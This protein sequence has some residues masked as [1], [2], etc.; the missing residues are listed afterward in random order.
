MRRTGQILA[1]VALALSSASAYAA[2]CAPQRLATLDIATLPAGRI[3]VPVTVEGHPLSFLLDTGGV[4]TTIKWDLAK[5]MGLAVKQADRRLHGMGDSTLNFVLASDK[6]SVG[7]LNLTD[8]PIYVE[9]RPL[10]DV[11]GTLSPDILRDYDVEIDLGAGHMNLFASGYCAMPQWLGGAVL[12]IDVVA[13][14]H[15][16][17]PVKIDGIRFV[18]VLDTGSANSLISMRAAALLS[19]YPSSPGLKL[20]ADNG[21]FQIYSYPFQT[22]DMGGVVVKSPHLSVASDGFIPGGDLV[23]GMDALRQMHLTIAYGSHRLYIKGP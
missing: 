16:Y 4:I 11:D 13:N 15:V 1:V 10:P 14:G 3:T 18:A 17:F 19:I 20:A 5:Q 8:K 22:L 6:F 2:D 23:L 9:S 12:P 21:Q 7:A